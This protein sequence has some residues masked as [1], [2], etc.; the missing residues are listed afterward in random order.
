[1]LNL[2]NLP[3][4]L[5]KQY[6]YISYIY[7]FNCKISRNVKNNITDFGSTFKKHNENY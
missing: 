5:E 1:M 7:M 2:N 3:E 4:A 6:I